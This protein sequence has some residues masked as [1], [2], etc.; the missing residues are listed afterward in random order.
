MKIWLLSI[1][2]KDTKKIGG[3]AEV[4]PR[5]GEELV[6]RGHE[7]Y[8]VTINNGF[9]TGNEGFKLL[10]E[11]E[12]REVKYRAYLYDKPFVKH[13]VI[14]GGS[15]DVKEVYSPRVLVSKVMEWSMVMK[16]FVEESLE[17]GN[18]PD[19]IHGNDWHSYPPLLSAKAVLD[20][21]GV[22]TRY[23]YHIHL[24]SRSKLDLGVFYEY[25]GIEPSTRVNGVFG[26]KS[27]KE[28]YDDS[29]GGYIERLAALTVDRVIT[30][31]RNYVVN[32]VRRIGLDL[33]NRVDYVYNATTWSFEKL[34][35]EART[36]NPDLSNLLSIDKALGRERILIRKELLTKLRER[37]NRCTEID[38][39]ESRRYIHSLTTH[40]F[41]NCGIVESF[42]SDGPLMVMTGRV[43]KQK[44]IDVLINATDF[45]L[46][47]LPELRLLLALLPVW[48]EK[49]EIESLVDYSLMFRDNVRVV[50]GKA[51]SI[52][53]LIHLSA[54]GLLAPSIYEPFGLMALEGMASGTPV[55]AS[56][57]GGLAETV[58]DIRDKGVLGTG[59]H[60]ETGS[61]RDLAINTVDLALFMETQYLEPWSSCWRDYV[62]RLSSVELRKIL[63]SNPNAPELVR[64]SC[65]NR[66]SCFNW[67]SSVDKL[68]SIYR[69]V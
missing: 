25:T 16:E 14:T 15:L 34:I 33:E 35:S 58:L 51:P 12:K 59:L 56:K 40:P 2:S 32:I 47:E 37:I 31:S 52:Y 28:Y 48:S 60:V 30:V 11:T 29:R 7:V 4:P 27:L 57:T 64:R 50:F 22:K 63:L 46:S 21:R 17:T 5:L 38:D 23:F 54:N 41:V 18:A 67:S 53:A 9:I 42:G 10:F 3:L 13:I 55:V 36:Y 69:G 66:A 39:E 26:F 65:L 61:W 49:R 6:K 19:V 8:L 62:D 43:A 44:G 68:V 45:I 24:I 20:N 1:E